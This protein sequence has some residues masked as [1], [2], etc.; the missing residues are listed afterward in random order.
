MRKLGNHSRINVLS[1]SVTRTSRVIPSPSAMSGRDLQRD[2]RK[3]IASVTTPPSP[4]MSNFEKRSAVGCTSRIKTMLRVSAP[5]RFFAGRRYVRKA[6][7]DDAG[8]G[9]RLF[10]GT[11]YAIGQKVRRNGDASPDAPRRPGPE[12][13]AGRELRYFGMNTRRTAESGSPRSDLTRQRGNASASMGASCSP[14]RLGRTGVGLFLPH[15]R[16]AQRKKPWPRRQGVRPTVEEVEFC[17]LTAALAGKVRGPLVDHSSAVSLN[18][19]IA[20]C[21]R[22]GLPKGA[23]DFLTVPGPFLRSA[24]SQDVHRSVGLPNWCFE[25]QPS[26]GDPEF[27]AMGR[28]SRFLAN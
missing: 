22:I 15:E 4:S 24:P 23:P 8:L 12:M 9:V 16:R 26:L 7:S 14:P 10:E 17:P 6:P 18:L 13:P 1:P 5:E 20:P 19:L 21:D 2:L 28:S 25:P 3:R 27:L 11:Q